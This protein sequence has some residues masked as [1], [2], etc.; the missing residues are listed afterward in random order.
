MA[1]SRRWDGAAC[2]LLA[3]VATMASTARGRKQGPCLDVTEPGT[4][5]SSSWSECRADSRGNL[6]GG[7]PEGKCRDGTWT[8]HRLGQPGHQQDSS[9]NTGLPV[10]ISLLVNKIKHT[11]SPRMRN[12]PYTGTGR[13]Q[14]HSPNGGAPSHGLGAPSTGGRA[15]ERPQT[16]ACLGKPAHSQQNGSPANQPSRQPARVGMSSF[17]RN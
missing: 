13:A 1:C 15:K 5:G 8:S 11:F 6:G 2:S 17:T 9:P 10:E 3:L 14:R 12:A 4:E 7:D 16:C